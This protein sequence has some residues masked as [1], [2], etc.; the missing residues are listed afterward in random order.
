[1]D[2]ILEFITI[3]AATA[4]DV[5]PIVAFMLF[6]YWVVLGQK[7]A[8]PRQLAIGFGFMMVGLGIFLLGLD[9]ALFPIGR[10]MVEQLT[11]V[12]VT[13]ATEAD[14][15]WTDYRLI[16]AFAFCI[17]FGAAIAEPALLAIAHKVYDITGGAIHPWG[18]RTAAA[19]GVATGVTIGCIRIAAGIP[20]HWCMAAG[21]AIVIIQ[22]AFSPRAI[23]PLAYDSGGVTTSVVTVPIVTALGLGLAQQV[24][25]RSEF[26]DGFGL[27]ALACVFPV[28]TVLGY[29]QIT[30][31]LEKRSPRR[32]AADHHEDPTSRE[33]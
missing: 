24:P 25:G 13:Y 5:L 2:L 16:F 28:I 21:Y 29:A 18:L 22:T 11:A 31:F 19:L 7:L 32:V 33:N 15:H 12:S 4:L 23:V 14:A 9:K 1:M 27:L 3:T 17:A 26:A 20:L 6:F 8:R 30:A 10:M